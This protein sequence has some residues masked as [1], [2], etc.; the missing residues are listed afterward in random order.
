MKTPCVRALATGSLVLALMQTPALA[1]EKA[2]VSRTAWLCASALVF[3]GTYLI[4]ERVEADYERVQ[5]RGE[6]ALVALPL[7]AAFGSDRGM[8]R[9]LDAIV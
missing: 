5:R 6:A 4:K 7:S 3:L 8:A 9:S 2:Q 1:A